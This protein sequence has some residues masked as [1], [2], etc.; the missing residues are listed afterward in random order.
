MASE[1]VFMRVAR[2]EAAPRSPVW[3]MR[4]AGRYLPEFRAMRAVHDFFTVRA[5]AAARACAPKAA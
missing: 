4:Q 3:A 2:G 5:A 1:S